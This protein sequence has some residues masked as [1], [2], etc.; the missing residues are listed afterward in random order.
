MKIQILLLCFVGVAYSDTSRTNMVPGRSTIVHLFEWKWKDIAEECERFLGPH[1]FG[2]VQVDIIF[3]L[4]KNKWQTSDGLLDGK[5][6]V[7][8]AGYGHLQDPRYLQC[9]VYV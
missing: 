4:S 7:V 8:T 6:S 5:W 2:G 9:V 1:G 3:F